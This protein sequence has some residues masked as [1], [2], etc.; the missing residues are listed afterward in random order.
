LYESCDEK[1]R[2]KN[3]G[4]NQ[5]FSHNVSLCRMRPAPSAYAGFSSEGVMPRML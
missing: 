5:Q 1:Y 3:T 4:K 2:H